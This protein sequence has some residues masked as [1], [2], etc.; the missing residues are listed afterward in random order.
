MV[1]DIWEDIQCLALTRFELCKFCS[2][3]SRDFFSIGNF[4]LRKLLE[5]GVVPFVLYRFLNCLM[6]YQ[7]NNFVALFCLVCAVIKVATHKRD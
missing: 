7:F 4:F 5:G 1:E 3:C 6:V 2:E